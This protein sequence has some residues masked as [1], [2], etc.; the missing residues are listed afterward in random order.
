MFPS[1]RLFFTRLNKQKFM[2]LKASRSMM[3]TSFFCELCIC[4]FVLALRINLAD[5]ISHALLT[6]HQDKTS[7][8]E[9]RAAKQR[10]DKMG[11]RK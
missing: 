6:S 3:V 2:E 7:R 4:G 5:S 9:F 10:L 11:N 1:C 8:L